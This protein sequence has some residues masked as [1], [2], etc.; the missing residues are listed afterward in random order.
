MKSVRLGF[1]LL[2][3]IAVAAGC[4]KKQSAPMPPVDA[5]NKPTEAATGAPTGD[6]LPAELQN[7][8]YAYYGLGAAKSM[9]YSVKTRTGQPARSTEEDGAVT[10]KLD[11]V[12]DGKA[13]YSMTRMD[14]GVLD[15]TDTIELSSEGVKVIA[16]DESKFDVPTLDL[17]AKIE[18]GKSWPV[19]TS[20]KSPTG[21]QLTLDGT[22][23]ID[24][25]QKV[26][27]KAGEYDTIAVVLDATITVGAQKGVAKG[28]SW[29]AKNVGLIKQEMS[30][31]LSGMTGTVSFELRPAPDESKK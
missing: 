27:V 1:L 4:T 11:S 24:R 18:V 26:K 19:K 14:L 10:V 20:F 17:P 30:Q 2:T 6:T 22:M 13:L 21:E 3:A 12:K 5:A 31:T 7:D 9:Y 23:K 29:Y 25:I 16:S 28:T 8:A 15:S